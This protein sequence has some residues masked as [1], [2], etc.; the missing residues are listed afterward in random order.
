MCERI[1][2]HHRWVL[3]LSEAERTTLEEGVRHHRDGEARERCKALLL[4][5]EGK[6]PHWVAKAGLLRPRDPDSIYHWLHWYEQEGIVFLHHRRH[7]G[8]RRRGL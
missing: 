4:V 8:A 3:H 1:Q 6:S 5:A 2:E 7:G